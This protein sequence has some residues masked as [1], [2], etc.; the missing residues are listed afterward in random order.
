LKNRTWNSQ[1]PTKRKKKK[2]KKKKKKSWKRRSRVW[3]WMESVRF[4][5]CL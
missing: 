4:A 5:K 1:A 2:K 3:E